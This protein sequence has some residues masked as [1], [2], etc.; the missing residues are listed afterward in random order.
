M[1]ACV[2]AAS[3]SSGPGPKMTAWGRVQAGCRHCPLLLPAA[4]ALQPAAAAAA[5]ATARPATAATARFSGP[6]PALGPAPLPAA[7]WSAATCLRPPW[8]PNATADGGVWRGACGAGGLCPYTP[9]PAYSTL[10]DAA[11]PPAQQF[12]DTAGGAYTG[13]KARRVCVCVCVRVCVCV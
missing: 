1:L 3:R 11:L 6:R 7:A 5:T 13:T 2:A 12:C 9:P 4:F 8:A 10:A